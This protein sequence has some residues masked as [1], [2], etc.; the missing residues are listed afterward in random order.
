MLIL[1]LKA[2]V[3]SSK[4]FL[5]LLTVLQLNT[6]SFH[7]SRTKFSLYWIKI[8]VNMC[9]CHIY[10]SNVYLSF[11]SW[12]IVSGT[13]HFKG[14]ASLWFSFVWINQ[15]KTS[16]NFVSRCNYCFVSHCPFYSNSSFTVYCFFCIK[17]RES[18]NYIYTDQPGNKNL[19]WSKE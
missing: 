5:G 18:K 12:V 16:N 8:T 6:I 13:G 9:N 1:L 3:Q 11:V 7:K 14:F 15:Q 2:T 4:C 17:F 19:I 10:I